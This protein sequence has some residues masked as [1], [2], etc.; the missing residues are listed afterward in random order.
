MKNEV[1]FY[2]NNPCIVIRDIN[3]EFS[4]VKLKPQY[5][6]EM[7][8][9]MWCEECLVGS[10]DSTPHAH[11][12]EEY[13]D[14]IDAINESEASIIVIVENRLLYDK[15]IEVASINDLQNKIGKL[16][17]EYQAYDKR[18]IQAKTEEQEAI[19]NKAGIKNRIKML[20]LR[21]ENLERTEAA[22]EARITKA[23]D[24]LKYIESG[25]K[26]ETKLSVSYKALKRYIEDSMKLEAL[27][28]AGVDNWVGYED[29]MTDCSDEKVDAALA[30]LLVNEKVDDTLATL[31]GNIKST[32]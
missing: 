11:T 10:S 23:E 32:L 28:V 5:A 4:E 19:S 27:E 18:L 6:A 26:E 15:P 3:G 20:E 21:K 14:V 2:M 25:S 30:I 7:D 1:K 17:A 8:G 16:K 9:S 22:I 31:S 29:A 13:Q 24:K 12:C